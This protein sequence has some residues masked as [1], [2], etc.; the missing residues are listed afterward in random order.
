MARGKF[1][2]I[3]GTE[4]A[5]KTLQSWHLRDKMEDHGYPVYLTM[6]CSEGPIGQLIRNEYLSGNRQV[7]RRMINYLY[8]A[9]RL[10]HITYPVDGMLHKI[11][12]GINVICDRYY[13]S[14]LALYSIE[15]F[16]TPHY[17]EE[18]DFIMKM[19]QA[20]S[21]LLQP[22]ITIF[23]D[24]TNETIQ[25]RL[26]GR[27]HK[28]EIYDNMKDIEITQHTYRLGIQLLQDRGEN[29]VFIDGNGS[30]QR[31]AHM[32]WE[33]VSKILEDS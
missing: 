29:I 25:K 33:E 9:D 17:F 20:A 4:G 3:E 18:M 8:A 11:E 26:G 6:E 13:L 16:N 7:D 28:I 24:V 19:N 2:V 15:F 23:L 10:D 21:E 12:Q 1:I 22:D 27:Q 30:T 31:V 5:G 32:V 14:S